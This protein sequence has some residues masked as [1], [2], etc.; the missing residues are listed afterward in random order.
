MLERLKLVPFG[1]D[2]LCIRQPTADFRSEC[3]DR[4]PGDR[5]HFPGRGAIQPKLECL[6]WRVAHRMVDR[7]PDVRLAVGPGGD[8][9]QRRLD[10]PRI[11]KR[12]TTLLPDHDRPRPVTEE[13]GTGSNLMTYDLVTPRGDAVTG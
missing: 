2:L 12:H 13:R 7:R 10:R 4:G 1:T 9:Q 11:R 8:Y 5:R 6:Q 3:A